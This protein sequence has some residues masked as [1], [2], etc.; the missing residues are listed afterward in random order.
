MLACQPAV[1]PSKG[2][3]MD[4][5][6]VES[7]YGDRYAVFTFFWVL[8]F[9]AEFLLPISRVTDPIAKALW[10]LAAIAFVVAFCRVSFR[11]YPAAVACRDGAVSV[12]APF[13]S[14]EFSAADVLHAG[15]RV[16]RCFGQHR[17]VIIVY[18]QSGGCGQLILSA[19]TP[20]AYD[21]LF[22]LQRTG[23]TGGLIGE[24]GQQL[25]ADWNSALV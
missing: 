21:L 7:S 25:G 2:M 22:H 12:K 3:V 19:D 14:S 6:V 11:L 15:L 18:S 24:A 17:Q 1:L 20:N 10:L 13:N 23:H 4:E 5:I 8:V 9:A 16:F